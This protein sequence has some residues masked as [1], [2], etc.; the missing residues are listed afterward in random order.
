MSP[1]ETFFVSVGVI[2]AIATGLAFLVVLAEMT[3]GHYGRM[4][5]DINNG[6]KLLDVEGGQSLLTTL[7]E[8]GIFIPSACGG[9][10]SCG[11][12]TLKVT[13][14]GGDYL[15]TELAWIKP[16]SREKG[17]RLSCQ[18]K[19]KRDM[20]IEVPSRLFSI[21]EFSGQV[22]YIED[23]THDIKRVRIRLTEPADISYKA[24][25]FMQLA[26]PEYELSS[27]QVSR[28]YSMSSAPHETGLVEFMIRLVPNGICTTWVHRYLKEGDRVSLTGPFGEF[29]LQETSREIICIAGGS[30]MA[31]IRSILADIEHRAH[32]QP[33]IAARRC[34]FFFGA[35]SR[36]DLFVL[37]EMQ[38]LEASLPAFTFIPALSAPK[39][40]DAWQGE[41]GLITDV[42]RKHLGTTGS[43]VEAYLCG[44][45]GMIKACI[46]VLNECGIP[47]DRIYYD[48][49]G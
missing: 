31:P 39:P 38:R 11:L 13:S 23:L 42:V 7:K 14:G 10:G 15:P 16:E 32:A 33:E 17:I 29:F 37:D 22:E 46:S 21:K 3:I 44:S 9:R 24:G 45:P 27:E 18:I 5:I 43:E 47:V 25:Q 8:E 26:V 36:R 49:F 30:G 1:L 2:T 20:S 48:S 19:V 40:E 12:C 4:K 6:E 41:S 35:V 28:A 34:R